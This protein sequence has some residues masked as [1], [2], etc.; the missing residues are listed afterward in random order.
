[1]ADVTEQTPLAEPRPKS[2][3][4]LVAAV[5]ALSLALGYAT[6]TAVNRR[7]LAFSGPDPVQIRLREDTS[8]CLAATRP[9]GRIVSDM[10]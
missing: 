7:F 5:A 8:Y 3:K 10:I 4:G 2:R 9:Q 6:V 1:M